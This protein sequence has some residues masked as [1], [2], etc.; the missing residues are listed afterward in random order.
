MGSAVCVDLAPVCGHCG[1]AEERLRAQYR[2][3]GKRCGASAL[4]VG[5]GLI[6]LEMMM[7]ARIVLSAVA[8]R[9]ARNVRIA[10]DDREPPV[11]GRQHEAGRNEGTQGKHGEHQHR[12]SVRCAIT[13]V[14]S[15]ASHTSQHEVD[16]G[17]VFGYGCPFVN[18][19]EHSRR[20]G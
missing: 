9:S 3:S 19:S 17:K 8:P 18:N 14:V 12:S 7:V 16:Q 4:S 11:D 1:C 10:Q 13:Q 2:R 15:S 20:R 5:A 6:E